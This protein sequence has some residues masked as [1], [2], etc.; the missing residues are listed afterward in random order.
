[1]ITLQRIGA[2]AARI[3]RSRLF[4]V[5][6]LAVVTATMVAAVSLNMRAITIID[7]DE[8]RVVLTLSREPLD[9]L[10][11]AGI[12]VGEDDVVTAEITKARAEISITRAFDVQVTADGVTTIVRMNGGTVGDALAKVGVEV[13]DNDRTNIEHSAEL[14]EGLSIE[15]ERVDYNEY[16]RTE[17]I[18]YDTTVKYVHS[19]SSGRTKIT[20]NGQEGLK[21]YT[22]R[23]RIVD[24]EVV[25][26]VLVSEEITQE[27]VNEIKTVGAPTGM[28]MSP[29]PYE[30][31]L[32]AQGRP[33]HYTQVL[34]GPATSYTN[35]GGRCGNYTASGRKAEVGTVAVNPNIIPYGTELY[36]MSP[37]GSYVYGYAIAADTGGALMSGHVLTDLFMAT[38]ADCS[39]FGRREMVVYVLG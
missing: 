12:T 39:Y 18:P 14:S 25:E 38:F 7:G 27:P 36:I 9:V 17:T 6:A 32:D 24:G 4:A 13:G 21:T 31:E 2:A 22:Y 1:M 8:S 3:V 10:Q 34:T 19:L 28:P 37:D 15:V 11:D 5:S 16:T 30:I 35:E 33:L 20:Q 26:T 29:A 23:D